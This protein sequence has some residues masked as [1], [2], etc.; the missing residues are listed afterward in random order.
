M[1]SGPSQRSSF[2]PQLQEPAL[3]VGNWDATKSDAPAE[4]LQRGFELAYF[5][6]P[7]RVTAIDI[8]T[9]ALE[10]IRARSR[11][12][13]KRL[14]WRDK[15]AERPVRR[16]ARSDMDML[17]WLIMFEAEQDERA[18]E[19]AG[20]I[21]SGT[22]AIRYIKHL[23]QITTALSSFYVNIGV[24][25]LLHN[26]STSE[27]QRAY[28]MLTSR[29]LGPDEYR[30]AKSALMDKMSER[31]AGFLKIA[32]V[33]HGELRFET[34]DDQERWVDAVSDSLSVFTPWSTQGHCAQFVSVNGNTKLKSAQ[35]PADT[36]QN[37]S[38]LRCCHILIEPTCYDQLMEDLAFDAPETRL[39]L[40]RFVMPDKQEK[41]DDNNLQTTRPPELSQEDLDQVQRRLAMTD[42]RR[43]N[44]NPRIVT[45]MIDGVEH[46]QLDLR[47]K[48]QLQVG[49]EAGAGLIE[50]RGSDERGD[51]LLATHFISY[52]NNAFESSRGKAKLGASELEFA[53]IP[54][55]TRGQRQ[56]QAILNLNYHARLQWA[57]PWIA[58]RDF[59]DFRLPLRAYVLAGL[60]MALIGWGV[61]GAFYS[62]KV[63]ELEQ[64]LQLARRNQQ[65]LSP[66][67]ARAII[68]YALIRDDLRVRGTETTGIPEISLHLHS[69]AISLEL[70]LTSTTGSTSYSAELKTFT[71][72]QTLMTQN[73][74]QPTRIENGLI[75]EI[76]VPVDLLKVGTYYTV[77]LHSSDRTDR[78]TFKVVD[79]Q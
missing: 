74:L 57:R 31:F 45:I 77:H 40:P 25:R 71:G 14:Y 48:H 11:R 47:E 18:Q 44:A 37:E 60:A 26:Y 6:I 22:M 68:S 16:I 61:A 10:K 27:A 78:F 4:L 9:R 79:R 75:V 35:K 55:A 63:K 12:E 21:S 49:L 67:S 39:A 69:P 38:E 1:R 43:R 70:P 13:M 62:H 20:S 2:S 42:A 76:V 66:T 51:L 73:F 34:S 64:K 32:R 59:A 52:A 53:V 23:I 7:D 29:F 17:Q 33:G 65:Q 24:S 5:L 46:A 50:I 36:D 72:D 58:W 3:P 30:R 8:L 56:L 41:S 28:E 19:R 54:V 15:H